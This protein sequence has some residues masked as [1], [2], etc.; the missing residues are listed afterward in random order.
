V[1][2][3]LLITV[4]GGCKGFVDA[5]NASV[6]RNRTVT[7]VIEGAVFG[8]TDANG[9]N[10]EGGQIPA[11]SATVFIELVARR[12]PAGQLAAALGATKLA[13]LLAEDLVSGFNDHFAP[14]DALGTVSVVDRGGRK[15]AHDLPKRGNTYTPTWSVVVPDV[16]IHRDRL[17]VELWDRDVWKDREMAKIVIHERDLLAAEESGELFAL[18]T[19]AETRGAVLRLVISVFR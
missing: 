14:P 12:Y 13:S 17:V 3:A 8:P 9:N 19:E 6:E 2:L 10:W 7:V 15:G 11:G 18:D 4:S 16:A 1:F 5:M